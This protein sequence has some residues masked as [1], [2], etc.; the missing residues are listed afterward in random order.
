[1]DYIWFAPSTVDLTSHQILNWALSEVINILYNS[2]IVTLYDI[3]QSK[4]QQETETGS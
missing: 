4:L 2:L 1:M 3:S